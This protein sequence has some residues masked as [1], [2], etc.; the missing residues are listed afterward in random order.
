MTSFTEAG[1]GTET[2]TGEPPESYTVECGE[3]PGGGDHQT[4]PAKR[5]RLCQATGS[6]RAQGF[7]PLFFPSFAEH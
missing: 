1:K 5:L 3:V 6:G 4:S 7:L 2:G